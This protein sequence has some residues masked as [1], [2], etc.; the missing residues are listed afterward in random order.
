MIKGIGLSV[1][2]GT[3]LLLEDAD[4]VVHPG[5]RVGLVG[6]NGSGKSTLFALMRGEM[7]ADAGA[8]EIPAA[9]R[10]ASVAQTIVDGQRT[11]CEYV[12]DGHQELRELERQREAAQNGAGETIANLELALEQAGAW[13]AK[14]RAQ[15][16]LAGLGF[17]SQEWD[18]PVNTFSGGWQMRIA[19]ARALMA[20]SELLLLDEPTNHLDLD[21]MIWLERWLAGYQGT[22]IIIS[23]DSEFLDAVCNTIVHIEQRKLTRYKGNYESFLSQRAERLRQTKIAWERQTQEAARLQRF[24]DR[25]KAKA[26]KAKQAQSRVKA[27]AR[28]Q[29]M[30]PLHAES[31]I[32]IRIPSP[33]DTPDR[34]LT[35][36]DTSVGYSDSHGAL[37]PVLSG[38]TARLEAGDR[39]GVLGVNGA[40][41]STLI[42]LIAGELEAISG[43]RLPSKALTVG[44]FAQHQME[45]LDRDASA[46]LH[47]VRLAPTANEQTLRNY[48]AQFGFT[49]DRVNESIA[50]FSGGEKARLALA[51]IVWNKPNLLILDEPSN[52]LDVETREA[53]T[54]A[55]AEYEGSLL[56]VSHDRHL[57]R[58][59]VDKF[60]LVAHGTVKPFDGDL[61][62]YRQQIT[63]FKP[64]RT[65][66]QDVLT[67]D[68]QNAPDRKQQRRE[69]AQA[70]QALAQARKP[71]EKALTA[72][73]S[74]LQTVS[75]RLAQIDTE[76]S[77]ES[78]YQDTDSQTRQR[79]MTEH[80]KLT[81]DKETLE[82]QCLELMEQ[83]E[84]LE[85]THLQ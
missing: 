56:L 3:Q 77:C 19:L 70:R 73:E 36:K 16:L 54:T 15:A 26:S 45:M 39:I 24:V 22:A 57:L 64:N 5:E 53:L 14:S 12:I 17:A 72:L 35:L 74:K 23:H 18:K 68:N 47:L 69:Q 34:L 59:T 33:D 67:E 4:F 76:L 78:F 51:L 79:V 46:L 50:P 82:I 80:G 6:R 63:S 7:D 75:N 11:A 55:L 84:A 31:A 48:L 62:D 52:H 27:L 83:L 65:L 66:P 42:K 9:W 30:A 37:T 8:V 20:P 40:G 32:D 81:Q 58:T 44:Y 38:V 41:K 61:D 13:Q 43:E 85:K 49:G 2:R 29:T 25:F 60:W 10:I 1:R 28:M 71:I 21:A